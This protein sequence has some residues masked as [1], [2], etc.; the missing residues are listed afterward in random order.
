MNKLKWLVAGAVVGVIAIAF[1]DWE[2]GGWLRPAGL[3]LDVVDAEREPVLGYDG[4]N[5]EALLEWLDSAELDSP[6]LEKMISYEER[7]LAREPVLETLADLL[8]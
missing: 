7:H 4:M 2:R 8:D 1:R 6:T 5:Q 3:G